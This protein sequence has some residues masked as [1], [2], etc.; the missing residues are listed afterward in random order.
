MSCNSYNVAE[1][2]VRREQ[3]IVF[4]TDYQRVENTAGGVGGQLP[5]NT[6]LCNLTGEY[7][8][9]ISERKVPEPGQSNRLVYTACTEV[10]EPVA[11]GGNTFA[12]RRCRLP[13]SVGN[14]LRRAYGRAMQILEPAWM[15]RKMLSTKSNTSWPQR[16]EVFCRGRRSAYAHT[17]SGGSFIWP[18]TNAVLSIT[19]D[20]FISH[21]KSLPS[22]T[23]ASPANAE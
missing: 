17:S 16:H 22:S 20:S 23:F 9:C 2:L 6:K 3:R 7:G 19:P 18:Y 21:H 11:I 8:G 4:F 15:K 12:M 14:L 1:W 13:E 5:D 10:M